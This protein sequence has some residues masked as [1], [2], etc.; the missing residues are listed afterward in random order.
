MNAREAV[1]WR[2]ISLLFECPGNDW[3]T[4]IRSLA[5]EVNDSD[6]QAAAAAAQEASESEYYTTFGP[7]GPAAP[8]EV[9]YRDTLMAGQVLG[10]LSGYYRVFA[11]QPMFAEVP[12]HVAVET[13][14]VAYL[15]LKEMYA[16]ETGNAEQ[17]K[18]AADAARQ[19]ITDHLNQMAEP[20]AKSLSYSGIKHLELAAAALLKRVGLRQKLP[21]A[22]EA[23]VM[24]CPAEAG[25]AF[26]TDE[27]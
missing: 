20:L 26:E 4:Q 11:Y 15:R 2:L 12:D 14:F 3:L 23:A 19:F 25:C 27:E 5:E 22:K 17:A 18:V 7:G 8:R 13:G 10:E 1:E 9:S 21:A 16:L 6:L 24:G